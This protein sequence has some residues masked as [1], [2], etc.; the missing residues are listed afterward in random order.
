VATL[1]TLLR[2]ETQNPADNVGPTVLALRDLLAAAGVKAA[3][4]IRSSVRWKLV[5][6]AASLLTTAFSSRALR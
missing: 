5:P 6:L 4:P 1:K 3:R 2:F